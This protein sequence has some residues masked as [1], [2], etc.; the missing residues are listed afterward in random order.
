MTIQVSIYR[1]RPFLTSIPANNK[2]HFHELIRRKKIRGLSKVNRLHNLLSFP[3]KTTISPRGAVKPSKDGMKT[4]AL[5][6]LFFMPTSA[7]RSLS[8]G[9]NILIIPSLLTKGHSITRAGV[10]PRVLV[11]S[12]YE[13][14]YGDNLCNVYL[15]KSGTQMSSLRTCPFY[16]ISQKLQIT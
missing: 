4:T 16:M 11:V 5:K 6:V 2:N 3:E 14:D 7:W 9:T 13:M 8:G 1:P 10:R 12:V 15:F